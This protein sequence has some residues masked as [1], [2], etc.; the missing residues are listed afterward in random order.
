MDVSFDSA[1]KII[2]Q[3]SK[4]FKANEKSY[5]NPNYSEAQVRKDFIDKF[6]I[7]L[8]WD[9]NHDFQKNP[10]EQEV[11]V[12]RIIQIA[13]AQKK[14]DYSFCLAPNYRDVKFFV[15]AKKPSRNLKNPD[16]FF[17]TIRYGWNANTPIAVLTDFEEFY[18]LDC[19]SRPDINTAL[20]QE[21]EYF[22]YSDYLKEENFRRIYHLFSHQSVSN[23]SLEIYADSLVKP[24]GKTVQR[25]LFK[26][27]FQSIDD[28]F[29]EELDTI[30]EDLAKSFK[31]NNNNLTSEELTE[32][33]QKT[34]D[35]LVFIRFLEDKLI[36]PDHY[37]S[38]F[39]EIKGAWLDFLNISRKL[40]AKYNGIVFKEHFIDLKLEISPDENIFSSI[41]EELSHINSPYNFDVIPIHILGSI[42]ERFLGNIVKVIGRGIKIE[43]KTE[44]RKAGG[45]YYT[46]Q[47]IV[48]YIVNNT[49]G[50]LISGKTPKQI[51]KLRF[52]DISC[53]SGS[54]LIT[55][56]DSL[57]DY[58]QKWY[59]ANPIQ[60][61]KEGCILLDGAW[62]LSLKQ[63]KEILINNIFGVDLD[64]QAVEVT[65]L[66]LYL[67]LL[68]D[69]TT[70]T[71]NDMMVLFKEKLLPD[72][73][74]NI[75]SGNSLL[76][77]DFLSTPL[78]DC[79]EENKFK[80]INF[81][82]VF[83]N[84]ISNGGFDAVFGNPPWIQSKYMDKNVKHYYSNKYYS[85][86]KQFDIFNGFIE[87][88]YNIL[89]QN[90]LLGYIIPTRF[91]MNNDYEL[92]RNYLLHNVNILQIADVGEHIFKRV[93]MPA[94]LLFFSKSEPSQNS[95]IKV[96]TNVKNLL[97]SNFSVNYIL[98]SRFI[99]EP[100]KKFTIY[101]DE[102]LHSIFTKVD[103]SSD[104]LSTFLYNARGVEIGKKNNIISPFKVPNSVKFLTGENISRYSI[105][106]HSWLILGK[107]N[108]DYKDPSLYVGP[109]III[110]K[111]G[112][113]IIATLD[114]NNYY[115][116]QVI[117]IFK[118]KTDCPNLSFILGVL[119]SK[120]IRA[121]YFAKF[122]EKDKKAFPHLTQ[123]KILELPLKR[124][125]YS[126]LS[127][128][129]TVD[130]II[131]AVNSILAAKKNLL[132]SRTESERSYLKLK[133]NSLENNIDSLVY[134][135][136]SL[137]DDEINIIESS[138]L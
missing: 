40:D 8:G 53:G 98:Q 115:V 7:A 42:Y 37:V 106:S 12:E 67:K 11:K 103:K 25:G 96:I 101:E 75:I 84:I 5:L 35:R 64:H 57:L 85:M 107:K 69:E 3:L 17:Q 90:G 31:K 134:K 102:V 22:H 128:K 50:K 44:V 26:G 4:D 78:F 110:R 32:A 81:N 74:N 114:D 136:Y 120:L 123:T 89:K 49:V 105:N 56:F 99:K 66:S 121:Y 9:V 77:Q 80:P 13:K 10:Y 94:S 131:T 130:D 82:E 27:G 38:E 124:V 97:T 116:I 54:F 65:Q 117:Y 76:E 135:L 125:N 58:H 91:L 33:T 52:V 19:R 2:S 100:K 126:K 71:T 60:A 79:N 73:N 48:K 92:L 28:A 23:Q 118:P 15:E 93:E 14:A 55:V 95:K 16:D 112:T 109:K 68:E 108:I 83:Q 24:K 86:K 88:G 129:K 119:N 39:G 113:G 46:P 137:T 36:E 111:T 30:R 18:I 20:D 34:I 61:K 63:K 43:E 122:G 104:K 6:F 41:C 29:L 45:V 70:A 133:C 62:R 1:F 87:K 21:I 132:N 72:L 47:Y 59:Q 138:I 127:D 51:S